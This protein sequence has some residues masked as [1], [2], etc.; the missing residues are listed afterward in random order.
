MDP[1]NTTNQMNSM[2]QPPVQQAPKHRTSL[3]AVIV[4]L[5]I[6]IIVTVLGFGRINSMKEE[7]AR[8]QSE[9]ARQAQMT[10]Q[11][12]AQIRAQN[13][14]IS[15]ESILK[16]LENINSSSNTADVTAIEAEF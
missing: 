10:A 15:E 11:K 4:F 6:A 9:Q 8:L 16:D 12:N 3:V 5:I 13:E 14:A 2:Y 1:F 7:D